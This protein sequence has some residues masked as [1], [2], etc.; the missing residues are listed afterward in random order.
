MSIFTHFPSNTLLI[1]PP[2]GDY[3]KYRNKKTKTSASK[4]QKPD[5]SIIEEV[6]IYVICI[7][8]EGI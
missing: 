5:K 1:L 3:N 8:N 2:P 4:K 6:L 7:R